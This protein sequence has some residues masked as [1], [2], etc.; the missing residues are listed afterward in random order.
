MRLISGRSGI[1]GRYAG[2]DTN[3]IDKNEILKQPELQDD[4][5]DGG[6]RRT[7]LSLSDPDLN[8]LSQD[9]KVALQMMG[10]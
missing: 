1:S 3:P 8:N 9:E 10:N 4:D 2:A 5:V 6:A 7:G